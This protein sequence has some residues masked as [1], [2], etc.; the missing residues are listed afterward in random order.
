MISADLDKSQ[1]RLRFT[2]AQRVGRDEMT[3]SMDHVMKLVSQAKPGFTLLTDLSQLESMDLAC[4]P[5]ID[6][7]MDACCRAGIR[8]VVR[9]VPDPTRDIG[10]GIMSLFHYGPEVRIVTCETLEEAESV[11]PPS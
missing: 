11:L 8:K 7:I 4:R 9:V 6:K 5:L 2:F 3:A 10:F 1:F